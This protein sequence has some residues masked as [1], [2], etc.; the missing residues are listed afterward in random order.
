MVAVLTVLANHLWAWPAGGFVGVD[1]FFVIS[2]FLITGNLLRDAEKRGTVSFRQFYWNRVRRIVPAATVVLILTYLAALVIFLPFRSQEVGIDALWA[3]A[4]LSNWWFGHEGTDY[5]RAAADTVSPI[6][7][8]WSLSIEEQFYFVWPAL[9]FVISAVVIRKAWGHERRMQLAGAAMGLIV[10]ASLAWALWET[11]TSP[12]WAYFNTFSR[13]WELGVGALL[14]CFVGVLA[15]IPR[16][17]APWLSWAGLLLIA[18]G[19]VV[20]S[21]QAAGF[22]APWAL[23]P[24]VG[25]ALVIAAGVGGEPAHQAFLRNPVSGYIGDISYSL[26]LVHWPVIVMLGT[27]VDTGFAFSIAALALSFGLAIA[28]YHFVENPMRRA[29]WTKFREIV[30]EIRKRRYRA[31]RSSGYAAVGALALTLVA[32]LAITLRPGAYEQTLPPDLTAAAPD[33]MAGNETQPEFG[34]LTTALQG[35]IL[36]ALKAT[37]WPA[38]DPS[39]EA[40]INDTAVALPPIPGCGGTVQQNACTW[41]SATAPTRV[42]IVGSSVAV[43]YVE[44]LKDIA[45]NSDGRIQLHTEAM[46]GCSFSSEL[47]TTADQLYL[48]ACPARKQHIVDLVNETKPDV[49]VISN[50]YDQ[51]SV[52]GTDRTLTP[53]EW[54]QS[55]RNLIDQFRASTRQ[56]VFLA[57][58]PGDVLISECFGKR[59]NT[60]ADCVGK[61]GNPWLSMAEAER[62]LAA[63]IGGV[64]IDSRPWFCRDGGGCPSF[65]GTTPT[66]LDA[67]HLVP[68]YGRKVAPVIAESLQHAGVF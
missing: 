44:P 24:V 22:P 11:A 2:G 45:V 48:E 68:A 28:S 1:V 36:N 42:L 10:A 26:Y 15:R 37:E 7:H 14:A 47:I 59:S 33:A 56:I 64:W 8:Y 6:Q 66:K 39:F 41:G 3:F 34:P 62:R 43:Y 35:E 55:V 17:A 57:P 58:P 9:I 27:L 49:V 40:V 18:A 20:I 29:D 21:E 60:P 19:V 53:A 52:H 5:F 51:K 67:T 25:A 54:T 63:D 13:V 38:L 32:L 31:R 65:V 16:A 50:T 46:P 61:P 4:F 12:L 23:L 30:R